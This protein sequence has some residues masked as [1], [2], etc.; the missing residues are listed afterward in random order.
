MGY[1]DKQN[2][3]RT[4]FPSGIIYDN[5]N[6]TYLTPE[7]NSFLVVSNSISTSYKGNEK[8][9]NQENYDLSLIVAGTVLI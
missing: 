2:L 9:I 4:I 1:T 6:H 5:E 8:G 7:I 3:Q